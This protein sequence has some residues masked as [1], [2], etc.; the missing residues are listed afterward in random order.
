M[1]ASQ[2]NYFYVVNYASINSLTRNNKKQLNRFQDSRLKTRRGGN[3]GQLANAIGDFAC[4]V[5]VFGSIC[6]TASCPVRD[7]SSTGTRVV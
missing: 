4:L 7:L 3:A 6:E 5:F 1:R 2:C